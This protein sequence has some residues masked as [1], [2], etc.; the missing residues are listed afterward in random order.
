MAKETKKVVKKVEKKTLT[1]EQVA[2]IVEA[3]MDAVN[4]RIDNILEALGKSKTLKGL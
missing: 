1:Q 2:Q 3:G 4:K